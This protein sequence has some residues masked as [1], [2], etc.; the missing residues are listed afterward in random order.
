MV[1]HSINTTCSACRTGQGA[2]FNLV[3]ATLFTLAYMDIS[4]ACGK[5]M[6]LV[7]N[8]LLR[9]RLLLYVRACTLWSCVLSILILCIVAA[10]HT[11]DDPPTLHGCII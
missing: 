11:F 4:A 3:S 2:K 10:M 6:S 9:D 1:V 8:W 5:I 7:Y